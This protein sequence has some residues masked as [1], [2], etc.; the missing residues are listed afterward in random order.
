MESPGCLYLMTI[1]LHPSADGS[2]DGTGP[3]FPWPGGLPMPT[4]DEAREVLLWSLSHYNEF[5]GQVEN[6][7]G[8][9]LLDPIAC[10]SPGG[11]F[12]DL[13]FAAEHNQLKRR[14]MRMPD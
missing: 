5:T 13:D 7:R 3:G 10:L 9:E 8:Y 12:P 4:A 11:W 14:A 2:T 1:G 6:G